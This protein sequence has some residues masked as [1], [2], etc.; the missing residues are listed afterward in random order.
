M[1]KKLVLQWEITDPPTRQTDNP[2]VSCLGC[3]LIRQNK[4]DVIQATRGRSVA[5]QCKRMVGSGNWN[6]LDGSDLNSPQTGAVY[7]Q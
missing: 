5:S 3:R 6:K 1:H 2:V 7:M 4:L